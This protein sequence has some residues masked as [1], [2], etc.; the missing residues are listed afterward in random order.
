MGELNPAHNFIDKSKEGK[1]NIP[2]FEGLL[3]IYIGGEG[4]ESSNRFN[5]ILASLNISYRKKSVKL[6]RHLINLIIDRHMIAI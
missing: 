2:D 5:G 3:Y 6:P 4:P 1:F